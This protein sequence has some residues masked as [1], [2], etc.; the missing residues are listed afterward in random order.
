MFVIQKRDSARQVARNSKWQRIQHTGL[1][2]GHVGRIE[3]RFQFLSFKYVAFSARMSYSRRIERWKCNFER[4]HRSAIN[5]VLIVCLAF[6]SGCD[7]KSQPKKQ[8]PGPQETLDQIRLTM[9]RG[10][11]LEAQSEAENAGKRFSHLSLEWVWKFRLIEAEI[12]DS[13]GLSQ[14]VLSLLSP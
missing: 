6:L 14:D 2:T 4:Q 9:F 5:W 12:L 7:S 1:R 8:L 10:N 11:F 13:R 3:H